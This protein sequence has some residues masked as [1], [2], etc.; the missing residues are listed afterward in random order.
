[1]SSGSNDEIVADLHS[2]VLENSKN[3]DL[4]TEKFGE[5]SQPE[6][7][8]QGM[9]RDKVKDDD[10]YDDNRTVTTETSGL[11]Y[12]QS[13]MT[14]DISRSGVS[15]AVS[16][17]ASDY[18]GSVYGDIDEDE[19]VEEIEWPEHACRFCGIHEPSCVVKCV[20]TGKWF[21]NGRGNTNQSHIVHHLVRSKYKEIQL[22]KDS[23]LGDAKCECYQCGSTN[24][25]LLGFIPA[26]KEE[27]V[28][29][30]CRD[31][32]LRD[33]ALKDSE[34][35]LTQWSPLI[36]I[37]RSCHGSFLS[38]QKRPRCVQSRSAAKR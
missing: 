4:S 27:I 38:R 22:H 17:G 37:R 25:F 3:T 13:V 21:C 28:V 29:L 32:C 23:P 1:M 16:D 35:D 7:K 30:L 10:I 14:N 11:T 20:K 33:G 34:W 5:T 15:R 12:D 9:Q 31:P 36:R 26:K 24:V 18:E 8:T 2:M 6:L 19:G